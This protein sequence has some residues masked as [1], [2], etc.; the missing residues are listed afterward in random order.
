MAKLAFGDIRKLY[1]ENCELKPLA[2]LDDERH[3]PG[4]RLFGMG[5]EVQAS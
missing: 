2:E 3:A 1:A 4:P 5:K